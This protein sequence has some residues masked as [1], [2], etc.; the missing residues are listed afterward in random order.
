MPSVI[1][2]DARSPDFE[3]A[4]RQAAKVLTDGGLVIFPTET[5]YG[6][7]ADHANAAALDR[8]AELKGPGGG[9]AR[10]PDLGPGV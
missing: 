5:F 4:L 7:A 2:I 8:L 1:S 10:G 6:I 3:S 9:K